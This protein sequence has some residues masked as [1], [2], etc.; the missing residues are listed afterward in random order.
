M[1]NAELCRLEQAEL[2]KL[3]E[4][5][6]LIY[7]PCKVGKE[8]YVINDV[9]GNLK[10]GEISEVFIDKIFTTLTIVINFGGYCQYYKSNNFGKTVFLTREQAK[11]KLKELNGN[12]K[13]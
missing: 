1:T 12:E 6:K 9:Y 11:Q 4:E 2:I 3:I 13:E 7:L 10:I 5:G 8:V